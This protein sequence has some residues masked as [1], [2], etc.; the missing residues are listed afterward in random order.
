MNKNPLAILISDIHF[1]L[2]NLKL[3]SASLRSALNHARIGLI[4]LVIA[5]DL[6]DTKPIIRAEVANELISL[7]KEFHDVKIHIL[8][9]NHDL[10]NEKGIGHG[11]NYLAPYAQIIDSYCSSSSLGS[12]V[13]FIPYQ[14]NSINLEE[15]KKHN[16]KII[17]MHQGV[18]GAW[19]GDY[20]QDKSSIDPELLKDYVVFSGHYH[21]HQKVGTITYIGSPY[22]ITYG[23]AQDGP[24][25]ILLLYSDGS[26]DQI[27]LS[28]RKH[29]IVE[30]IIETYKSPVKEYVEGDLLWLK[31]H[32]LREE[33]NKIDKKAIKY[34][35][36]RLDLIP[37]KIEIQGEEKKEDLTQFADGHILDSLIDKLPNTDKFKMTLKEFWKTLLYETYET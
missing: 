3:A 22:T 5:G 14:T 13:L 8:A 30:R 19:M 6:N 29:I 21:R 34:N 12:N 16:S 20:I 11:L 15:V 26:H 9:G 28:L 17:I 25:G 27:V 18:K 2:N 31:I 33:L 36:L 35:N 37:T 1:S 23:E 24:K 7:F 4:P 10:I 32:G